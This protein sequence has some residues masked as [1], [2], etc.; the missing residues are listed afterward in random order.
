MGQNPV[1]VKAILRR[2]RWK[3]CL[4]ILDTY[5]WCR[6]LSR[7][8]RR[9][10]DQRV[11]HKPRIADQSWRDCETARRCRGWC[12]R[13]GRSFVHFSCQQSIWKIGVGQE[14]FAKKIEKKSYKKAWRKPGWMGII[15]H[16]KGMPPPPLPPRGGRGGVA[17]SVPAWLF[18]NSKKPRCLSHRGYCITYSISSIISSA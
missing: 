1:G 3:R 5:R 18:I 9:G 8:T 4:D 6:T 16:P 11:F 17:T 7:S 10:T 12:C 14:I 15:G 13:G 2:G